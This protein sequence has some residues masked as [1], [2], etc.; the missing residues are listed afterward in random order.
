MHLRSREDNAKPDKCYE[1]C[2]ATND[3]VDGH[4][5]DDADDDLPY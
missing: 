4:D 2:R 1:T 3:V 5:D